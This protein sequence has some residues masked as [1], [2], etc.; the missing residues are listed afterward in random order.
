MAYFKMLFVSQ[1]VHGLFT[2]LE[3][4]PKDAIETEVLYLPSMTCSLVPTK[5]SSHIKARL[6]P[7]RARHLRQH[8]EIALKSIPCILCCTVT[9]DRSVSINNVTPLWPVRDA[10]SQC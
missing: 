3:R 8:C 4:H 7:A 9:P 1:A 5:V 10:S 2:T 6:H